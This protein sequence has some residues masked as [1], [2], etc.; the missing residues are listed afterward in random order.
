MNP[1]TSGMS[2]SGLPYLLPATERSV[3]LL[4]KLCCHGHPLY[5]RVRVE[6]RCTNITDN[7]ISQCASLFARCFRLQRSF[8]SLCRKPES[9]EDQ[10]AHVSAYRTIL[11]CGE[12]L[13]RADRRSANC[14]EH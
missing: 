1:S 3:C 14:P 2:G 10:D 5:R 11:V 6:P 8:R 9:V 13:R 4:Q 12:V 7:L